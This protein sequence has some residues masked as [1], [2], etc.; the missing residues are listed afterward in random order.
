MN[1]Q[2]TYSDIEK[3]I[4]FF[5]STKPNIFFTSGEILN[6]LIDMNICSD[7]KN[8]INLLCFEMEFEN[9]CKNVLKQFPKIKNVD[10]KYVFST[11]KI[12]D[13][14][15]IKKCISSPDEIVNLNF[16]SIYANGQTILHILCKNAL[17][18]YIDIVSKV[19]EINPHMKNDFNETLFEVIPFSTDGHETF[20]VLF[21]IF[22]TDLSTKNSIIEKLA[23]K[24]TYLSEKNKELTASI[25]IY[26]LNITKNEQTIEHLNGL[27]NC[28]FFQSIIIFGLISYLF[29]TFTN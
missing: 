21:N 2:C 9:K 29:F 11:E 8:K 14:E 1:Y 17:Y 15:H 13:L 12:I 6:N 23:D 18:K 16:T 4:C 20:K 3:G 7:L 27:D 22:V 19:V 10:D 26:D 28:C 25:E 24:N 5:L